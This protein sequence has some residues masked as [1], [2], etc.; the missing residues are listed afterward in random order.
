ML[1]NSFAFLIFLPVVFILHWLFTA[2]AKNNWQNVILLIAS[3]YFY[4]S[5][6]YKFLFLL[7][8][9]TALDYFLAIFI[10]D[11]KSPKQKKI[12]LITSVA[13]NLGFLAVF[14]Y[15]NFFVGSVQNLFSNF[16][17]H[18][19]I[20][21]LNVV[22]P[23]GI[24]F[25]TFHGLS[26]IIDVYNKKIQPEKDFVI[27]SLFVSFFPLLVAGPIERATHLLPQLKQKREF[28]Y[29]ILVDGLRQILWGFFKK[30]VIADNCAFYVNQVFNE[31]THF[32]GSSHLL[33]I[34]LFSFQIYADFS[35]YS[36]IAIG[37]AKLFGIELIRNFNYPYFSRNVGEFWRKWH[38]SLTSWFRDYVYIPIGGSKSKK[39]IV[40]RNTI[41]IF[42]LSGLWHGANWTFVFW[43]LL[44]SIYYFPLIY[45][46]STRKYL[47]PIGANKVLPSFKQFC[48]I[49]VTFSLI[50]IS[51]IFFRAENLN[52]AF[53]FINK[54]F[55]I[56]LVSK[57]LHAPYTL[58]FNICILICIE[59]FGRL[60]EYPIKNIG[61][62]NNNII[63]WILYII[64]TYYILI[65][66]ATSNNQFI[67]FQF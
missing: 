58:L 66:M 23:V 49:L 5:W 29:D 39:I 43:G 18:P 30:M 6:N 24:S 35:G 15:Y 3:Y 61:R 42:I 46:N 8:F 21:L 51:W 34:F 36:D 37:T 67:Y 54:L 22:L 48:Q 27:Y 57:P 16:G 32:N 60:Y 45:L 47:E 12:Y 38:I 55:S 41:V 40:I 14:K 25:Y 33:A 28:E 13:I 7:L 1:F 59:W 19:D 20:V 44:N 2:K 17:L 10:S 52:K 11:A 56:S 64:L 65:F 63:R 31:S 53:E 62:I 26:Y 9:S 4:G 50:S